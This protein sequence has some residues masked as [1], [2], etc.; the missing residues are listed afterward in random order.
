ME[1]VAPIPD[2]DLLAQVARARNLSQS[3]EATA[4][5]N[6]A[7]KYD[8]LKT[9]LADAYGEHFVGRVVWKTNQ[10]PPEDTKRIPVNDLHYVLALMNVRAYHPGLRVP[11]EVF[12]RPGLIIREYVEAEGE[13]EQT[14]RRLERALPLLL[15]LYDHIYLGIAKSDPAYPWTTGRLEEDVRR[16]PTV[17]PFFGDPCPVKVDRAFV[18]PVFAA[19]RQLLVESKSGD[20][21]LL[22]DPLALFD[23][24]C[25]EIV[26]KLKS[27]HQE[28]ARGLLQ[29]MGRD[30]EL[31]I[32]LESIV[33]MEVRWRRR[34]GSLG[35]PSPCRPRR[36]KCGRDRQEFVPTEEEAYRSGNAVT[37]RRPTLLRFR[38]QSYPVSTWKELYVTSAAL[39]ARMYPTQFD[40][41]AQELM[42]RIRRY[43]SRSRDGMHAPEPVP[44]T[45]LFME[46][47][48]SAEATQQRVAELF[49]QF[50][51]LRGEWNVEL[52]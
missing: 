42:G 37:N 17:T 7:G 24:K 9:I 49:Q 26:D 30:K 5:A 22:L 48:F 40:P 41:K 6:L 38:G 39:L 12:S 19:F 44:G 45:K 21:D 15:E 28:N 46:T 14:Y 13:Q 52:E 20:F 29:V 2:A 33:E 31:W 51:H 1:V 43:F 18:W 32:R 47:C 3:V 25:A 34:D 23:E 27:F 16:R 11:T 8:H 50:G 10:K 35:V 36:Q 4:L